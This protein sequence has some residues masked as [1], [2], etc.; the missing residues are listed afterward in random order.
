M[1]IVSNTEN[2]PARRD[3]ELK[4]LAV[5]NYMQ[6]KY[7]RLMQTLAFQAKKQNKVYEEFEGVIALKIKCERE[8]GYA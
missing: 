6:A 2:N 3:R 4:T 8:L 1:S 7:L 5:T